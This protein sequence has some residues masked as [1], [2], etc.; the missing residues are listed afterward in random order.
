MLAGVWYLIVAVDLIRPRRVPIAAMI[1]AL[2][3]LT[4]SRTYACATGNSWIGD[5]TAQT[6]E[7]QQSL[8]ITLRGG[9]LHITGVAVWYD[10]TNAA[11]DLIPSGY[12]TTIVDP[13]NSDRVS[14]SPGD[15]PGCIVH[16]RLF[17][18]K[19]I[20]HDNQ[21]CGGMNVTFTGAYRRR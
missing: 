20:A 14:L 4:S 21:L 8:T 5:W 17:V 13:P 1:V 18:R 7:N 16:L 12:F 2:A 3:M 19:L 11:R 9:K 6:G 15:L 10:R